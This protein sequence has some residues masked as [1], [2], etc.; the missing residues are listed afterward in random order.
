MSS[1]IPRKFHEV[2]ATLLERSPFTHRE[3]AARLGYNRSNIVTMFKKGD[4][5]VPIN[6][7]P[8]FALV[9]EVDAAWLMRLARERNGGF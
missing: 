6:K 9:F 5:P 1:P 7:I 8:A 2:I 4:T 3:I